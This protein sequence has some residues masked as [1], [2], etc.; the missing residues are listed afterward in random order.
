MTTLVAA[1]VTLVPGLVLGP[2]RRPEEAH[3]I[4]R[5][6]NTSRLGAGSLFVVT[7]EMLRSSPDHLVNSDL[8]ADLRLAEVDGRPV[9][10]VRVQWTDE[11]RG[12]R[13]PSASLFVTPDAPAGSVSALLDWILARHL[14]VARASGAVA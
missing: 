2:F 12:G 3:L 14:D 11:N 10:H 6:N 1:V 8:A 7:V 4:A 5:I 9:G 13:I